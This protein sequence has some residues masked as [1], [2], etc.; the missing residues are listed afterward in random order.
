MPL[1]KLQDTKQAAQHRVI[2]VD[3]GTT[4][5]V[6]AAAD[7]EG[8]VQVLSIGRDLGD[9]VPTRLN[10]GGVQLVDAPEAPAIDGFKRAME[11]PNQPVAGCAQTPQQLSAAV[12]RALKTRT[13][14]S[15]GAEVAGAVITVPAHFSNV[16]REATKAA[17]RDAGLPVMRLLN[18]PTAAA[19]A[20][21]LQKE[22]DRGT[23]LVY[24]FGGGTFDVTVLHREQDVF[25]VLGSDGDLHLGGSDI[26]AA[27][28]AAAGVHAPSA[29]QKHAARLLKESGKA[30]LSILP[31]SQASFDAIM[32]DFFKK[33]A[34][35]VQTM[36]ASLQ[37]EPVDID[38]V[39]LVGGASRAGTVSDGMKDWFGTQKILRDI[40]PDRAVAIGAA[41]H[42]G[43]L[44]DPHQHAARPLLLDI[45]P[46]ALGIETASGVV[47]SIIPR[48]TPT[49]IRVKM[50]FSTFYNN[51]TDIL[52]HIVQGNATMVADCTSL[53]RFVLAGIPP[54]PS[55]Q[56]QI[57]VVFSV[58]EDGVV[59]V[60]AK[61]KISGA[62]ASIS[63]EPVY[64]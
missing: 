44:Q 61:E 4:Y 13:E 2:G 16:A 28:L 30:N 38:K 33:T 10:A 47:E 42:A 64:L 60:E 23:Y 7:A 52:I 45:V 21:G 31:L 43:A 39:L 5:S 32:R 57:E 11:R 15:L 62:E 6:V 27:L 59:A 48:Y 55:G 41:L 36:L 8:P 22:S 29:V 40:D 56:P 51:Q 19:L 3:L 18:E 24:D 37:L 9:L 12:L 49:P 34:K 17:A 63:L 53:G 50:G 58:D 20:Y 35:I 54:M 46:S 1:V 26:D 25:Q 14:K